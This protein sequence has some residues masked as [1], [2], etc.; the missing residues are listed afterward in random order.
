MGSKVQKKETKGQPQTD[1]VAKTL[2]I[3]ISS[4]VNKKINENSN[5]IDKMS[6]SA[7]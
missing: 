5:N 1:L 4:N 2:K 6:V 7:G 3:A